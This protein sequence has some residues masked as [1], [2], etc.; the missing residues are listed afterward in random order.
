M[1]AKRD[2]Y[3]ILGVGRSASKEEIKGA[4]RKLALQF[5][6][7]RNKE[8]GAEEKFKEFSEAYAVLSDVEKRRTYDMYGHTGFDQRY[9]QEDIFR[10]TNFEDLFREMHIQFGGGGRDDQFFGGRS[11]RPVGF[12]DMFGS[13]F[14]QGFNVRSRG[15]RR[16]EVGESLRVNVQVTLEEAATGAERS[17]EIKHTVQCSKCNGSRS[18]GGGGAEKCPKC[19]G[20]GQVQSVRSMGAFGR[21]V[22]LSTC[23]NC[24][25]EGAVVKSPCKQCKGKGSVGENEFVSVKIPAGVEDGARLRLEG[26]GNYGKDGNGDAYVFVFVKEHQMFKREGEDV[27][28]EVPI[29]FAQAALG[30]EIEV[31]TLAGKAKMKVPAGTQTDTVFRLRGEGMPSG[32]S[33]GVMTSFSQGG[34]RAQKGDELV[35]VIVKTPTS[36]SEKQKQLLK[37]LEKEQGGMFGGMFR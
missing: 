28:I 12:E 16:R 33:K 6:P 11:A 36:L 23:P 17:L 25:G 35:R 22:S 30:A 20:N 32:R 21:F 34:Q 18:E 10:G 3:E 1:A 19:N 7:D 9:S 29:S 26:M 31:P 14:G 5:H 2:Y 8:A 15:G 24:R 13:F 27:Y 4:Y 37:E